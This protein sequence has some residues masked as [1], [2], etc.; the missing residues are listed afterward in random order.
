MQG[1]EFRLRNDRV[2]EY[3]PMIMYWTAYGQHLEGFIPWIVLFGVGVVRCVLE[4]T[5]LSGRASWA[6]KGGE[7]YEPW[8][9]LCCG[10]GLWDS[11][12][13]SYLL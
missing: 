7:G 9:V 8:F 12:L 3:S 4:V 11:K 6:G 1:A 2:L 13:K 5:T 10:A